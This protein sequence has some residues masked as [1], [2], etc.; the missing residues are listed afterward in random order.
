MHKE[1]T[2]LQQ[3]K[4][5][6]TLASAFGEWK[7]ITN[8]Q[9]KP[10][11][12]HKVQV[13]Y[14]KSRYFHNWLGLLKRLQQEHMKERVAG[15]FRAVSLVS[16]LFKSL[17]F[18]TLIHKVEG[19]KLI[20]SMLLLTSEEFQ[21]IGSSDTLSD[22]IRHSQSKMSA[23]AEQLSSNDDLNAVDTINMMFVRFMDAYEA[24]IH[25][26]QS[27]L[28]LTVFEKTIFSPS[29]KYFL[30]DLVKKC[31]CRKL[32]FDEIAQLTR[33]SSFYSESLK[34]KGMK[35]F[36]LQ[37]AHDLRRAE[38]AEKSLEKIRLNF[39]GEVFFKVCRK[40]IL[41]NELQAN[42][43]TLIEPRRKVTDVKNS[44]YFLRSWRRACQSKREKKKELIAEEFSASRLLAKAFYCLKTIQ[45]L[46]LD[47]AVG[48]GGLEKLFRQTKLLTFE[49]IY[50][51]DWARENRFVRK[52]KESLL[53][54]CFTSLKAETALSKALKLIQLKRLFSR[55]LL[56]AHRYESDARL[57][58]HTTNLL[59]KG[60]IGFKVSLG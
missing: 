19:I 24:K 1:I 16:R 49:S 30:Q 53:R 6:R 20:S 14:S 23:I 33:A 29:Q 42:F 38:E 48:V 50:S 7:L 17:K 41:L 39:Y 47:G 44:L 60:L 4:S 10:R 26:G 21:D 43:K 52:R 37:A 9:A 45:E 27:V 32:Y 56:F 28:P 3:E 40:L 34:K 2:R 8:E 57:K 58:F 36:A 12:L 46:R 11:A 5:R 59:Y 31:R 13:V 51:S 18:Y 54:S 35:A 55:W 15:S 22:L 25:K